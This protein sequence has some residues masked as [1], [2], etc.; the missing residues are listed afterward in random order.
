MGK[1]KTPK[2]ERLLDEYGCVV[3][4]NSRRPRPQHRLLIGTPTLGNVRIEW[5][6]ARYGQVVPCNWSHANYVHQVSNAV[7]MGYL[8]ADAQNVIVAEALRQDFEWLLLI[9]DDTLPP[10]DAFVR[11]NE[12]MRAGDVPVVSGLYYTKGMPP[13]P[14]VYRGRGNSFYDDFVLGEKVWADGVPTG[15]L[16]IHCSILRL[17][18]EESEEYRVDSSD[19]RLRRVFEQP[20]FVQFDDTARTWRV[21]SG[22]SDLRWCDRVMTGDYLRRAGWKRIGKRRYP[23]LVDTG[24]FCRHIAPDGRMYPPEGLLPNARPKPKAK[25]RR[26]K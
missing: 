6:M 16:L 14:L 4:K 22:T 23:F 17:M 21:A 20:E 1:T 5:V 26:S 12:Y 8:V 3:V 11:F 7:P 25:R 19:L 10:P 15:C 13:E 2:D 24:I 9:E 18:A